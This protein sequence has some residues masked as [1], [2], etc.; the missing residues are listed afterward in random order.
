MYIL[1]KMFFFEK[2]EYYFFI[3]CFAWDGIPINKLRVK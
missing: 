2:Y 3:D 1:I